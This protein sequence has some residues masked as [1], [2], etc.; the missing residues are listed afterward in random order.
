M[1]ILFISVN[2]ELGV[3]TPF[4][5]GLA[6]VAAATEKAGHD[7]QLLTPISTSDPESSVR[8]GIKGTR[9]QVIGVSVRNIDDQNMQAPRF[10]LEPLRRVVAVCRSLS[11]AR[12]V[13]GGAGYS[14]FPE[15][16]LTYLG[17]DMGI[18]GE[19]ESAFPR[20]LS[21]LERG[22]EGGPPS[23]YLPG[24]PPAA[25]D[26]AAN[27]D[28]FPMPAPRLWLNT[29]HN[30]DIRVPVQ[31]RRGCPLDC[32]YC[33]TSAIEGRSFRKRSRESVV[34]WLREMRESGFRNFYFVDNAFNLSPSYAKELCREII[35]AQLD[36]DWWSIVY[37]K[38]VD[39]E[40]ASLMAKAGCTQVS[41]GF[42]S[43]SEPI[44]KQ[45]NKRFTCREVRAVS[46]T[47]SDAGIKRNG[48]LLLGGPAETR[49]TVEE[50]LAFADSLD[51][52]ALKVTVGLRIYPNTALASRA[53]AE[54]VIRPD[55][56]LLRP[57]FYLAHGLEDWLPDRIAAWERNPASAT[58][59]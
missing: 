25:R 27:L 56:N 28:A 30:S 45:L 9:P 8:E 2:D 58:A 3:E 42:E 52:H 11:G 31:S 23:V 13:L 12:I 18:Q 21:W 35:R 37:P 17:A 26:F 40:L 19:G 34:E 20:L 10:L 47:L 54:G 4:P 33:S 59:N 24:R 32:A 50:S 57:R 49:D 36:I 53:V 16:V 22:A 39:V 15:S 1:K 43:G 41:L 5:L 44:L 55:D 7:V 38:W 6:C 29:V 14:I 51:L 46:A 48:F